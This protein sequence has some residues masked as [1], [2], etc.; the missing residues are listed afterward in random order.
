MVS[1]LW[2]QCALSATVLNRK[3]NAEKT[4]MPVPP[5]KTTNTQKEMMEIKGELLD[6]KRPVE[7]MAGA[8]DISCG[9]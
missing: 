4:D 3:R 8:G 9:E 1:F 5:I 6:D 2:I 7:H